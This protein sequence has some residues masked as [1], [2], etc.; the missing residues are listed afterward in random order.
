MFKPRSLFGKFAGRSRLALL[1]A[2]V[3]VLAVAI[4]KAPFLLVRLLRRHWP[5]QVFLPVAHVRELK[6]RRV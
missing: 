6:V 1:A 2:V 3:V 5:G 4:L